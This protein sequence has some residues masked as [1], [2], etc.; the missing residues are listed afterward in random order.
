MANTE[1]L[2]INE[3]PRPQGA[4]EK[5]AYTVTTTPWGSSPSTPSVVV[6]DDTGADV[7]A[8]V[9]SGSTTVAADVITLLFIQTLTAGEVYRVEIKFTS[10]G[11]VFECFMIIHART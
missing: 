5:I 3:S 9:T 11:N 6:K 10:G 2:E 1:A 7:T 8:T 4:D